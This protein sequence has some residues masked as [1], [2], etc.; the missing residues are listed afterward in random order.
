MTRTPGRWRAA[1]TVVCAMAWMCASSCG[2]LQFDKTPAPTRDQ[3]QRL[4]DS[5]AS[6]AQVTRELGD[7]F[8]LYA[9]GTP[10][11]QALER[12]NA[13]RY[14]VAL[15]ARYPRVVSYTTSYQQ[16]WLFFDAAGTLREFR[17][18]SQ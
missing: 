4:V 9:R 16:T 6:Q 3:L 10:V 17:V 13:P 18:D 14:V 5:H 12:G 8:T 2:T 1:S 15:S 7:G 11:W